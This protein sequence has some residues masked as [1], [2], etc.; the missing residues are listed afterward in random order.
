MT[1]RTKVYLSTVHGEE[2]DKGG[3]KNL[4]KPLQ[5]DPLQRVGVTNFP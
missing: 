4:Q 3:N 5:V 2:G 1:H